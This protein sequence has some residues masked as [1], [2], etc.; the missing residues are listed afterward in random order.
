MVADI[1]TLG[2]KAGDRLEPSDLLWDVASFEASEAFPARVLFWRV[3]AETL[4]RHRNPLFG[5]DQRCSPLTI[6][7]Y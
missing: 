1:P 7:T 5:T 6:C 4:T 3:Q 2:L